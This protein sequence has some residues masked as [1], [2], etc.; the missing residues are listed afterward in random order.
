VAAIF[1]LTVPVLPAV[2]SFDGETVRIAYGTDLLI[3]NS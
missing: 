1:A 3:G 2:A